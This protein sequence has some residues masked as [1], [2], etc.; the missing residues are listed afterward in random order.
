MDKD[1][2]NDKDHSNIQISNLHMEGHQIKGKDSRDHHI[3][4]N[5]RIKETRTILL[6]QTTTTIRINLQDI[7]R[8]IKEI[9][10][11]RKETII[12]IGSNILQTN[13]KEGGHLR[14][15]NSL[16]VMVKT[17]RHIISSKD[18]DSRVIGSN[19]I[20]AS[21]TQIGKT[22]IIIRVTNLRT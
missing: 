12:T 20:K 10:L 11:I 14:A 7:T 21:K 1:K 17:N 19:G 16:K 22:T 18:T 9:I 3:T 4:N 6:D 8:L 2:D 15:P 13:P 5:N